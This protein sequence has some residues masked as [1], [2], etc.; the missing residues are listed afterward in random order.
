MLALDFEDDSSDDDGGAGGLELNFEVG[1]RVGHECSL[2]GYDGKL[3]EFELIGDGL[4]I[5]VKYG[6]WESGGVVDR[7]EP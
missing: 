5:G 6:E 2:G 4:G 3:S 7:T 1:D